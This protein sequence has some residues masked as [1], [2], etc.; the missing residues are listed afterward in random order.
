MNKAWTTNILNNYINK[1]NLDSGLHMR[2]GAKD[3]S[4]PSIPKFHL[5]RADFP[6]VLSL[7]SPL[8]ILPLLLQNLSRE[9][10]A[11]SPEDTE[12]EE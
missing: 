6:G 10:P 3:I 9:G 5:E 1:K 11:R 7:L 2:P 8:V 12:T 4:Q